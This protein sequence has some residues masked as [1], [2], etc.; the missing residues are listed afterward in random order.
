ML[1]D[2]AVIISIFALIGYVHLRMTH[3][4]S[5]NDLFTIGDHSIFGFIM[6]ITYELVTTGIIFSF[7]LF[8]E[9]AVICSI[10]GIFIFG[11]FLS[12]E[13]LPI[14]FNKLMKKIKD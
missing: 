10:L 6:L 1:R 2:L 3:G 13:V 7:S 8:I 14:L 5:P 9:L 12:K 4:I 11:L